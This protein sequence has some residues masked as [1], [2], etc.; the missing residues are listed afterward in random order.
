MYI[1]YSRC[2]LR[3]YS[4]LVT[5]LLLA[6]VLIIIKRFLAICIYLAYARRY[7]KKSCVWSLYINLY[8]YPRLVVYFFFFFFF[9][10]IKCM[11]CVHYCWIVYQYRGMCIIWVCKYVLSVSVCAKTI[12]L[13]TYIV[14]KIFYFANG[15]VGLAIGVDC[16]S[17]I[18]HEPPHFRPFLFT[19]VLIEFSDGKRGPEKISF[20]AVVTFGAISG[21][22]MWLQ[23]LNAPDT[24]NMFVYII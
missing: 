2:I 7:L 6:V 23:M 1:Q 17:W 22:K 5:R 8:F 4:L 12:L 24:Y 18:L 14:R 20:A 15:W 21:L 13:L 3:I 9:F 19:I 11:V 16:Q 10:Y